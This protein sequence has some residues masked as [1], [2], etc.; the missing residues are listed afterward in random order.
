MIEFKPTST[1]IKYFKLISILLLIILYIFTAH[2][3]YHQELWLLP[4][5]PAGIRTSTTIYILQP[6][7]A[8]VTSFFIFAFEVERYDKSFHKSKLLFS[9]IL[10][11]PIRILEVMGNLSY[12]V[13]IWHIPIIYKIGS[14]FTSPLALEAFNL[15][16]TATLTLSLLL[17]TVTYYVVELPTAQWKLLRSKRK[18]EENID[19]IF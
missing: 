18:S 7:T 19:Q 17:A 3:I 15:R 10:K 4:N 2:H 11:N 12:G 5:R 16:L 13:Y 6:L 1:N 9:S 8:I 14:I